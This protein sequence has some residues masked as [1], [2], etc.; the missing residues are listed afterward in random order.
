MYR[1]LPA[2]LFCWLA[3]SSQTD[4]TH[5]GDLRLDRIQAAAKAY[6]RDVGEFPMTAA[7][8]VVVTDTSGRPKERSEGS[9]RFVFHGYNAR[10]ETGVF[11]LYLGKRENK[12]IKEGAMTGGDAVLLVGLKLRKAADGAVAIEQPAQAGQPLL[13]GIRE[14]LCP[15]FGRSEGRRDIRNFCGR[16]EYRLMPEGTDGLRLQHFNLDS[17]NLPAKADTAALGTVQVLTYHVDEDFEEAL[18][19]G[20]PKPFLVPKRNVTTIGTNKGKIVVTNQ[21]APETPGGRARH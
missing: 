13:V 4:S 18:L 11:T 17:T 14:P 9:V 6:L 16:S 7:V 3:A 8:A 10:A 19:P 15:E 2:L 20:D 5:G 12:V 1:V 21:Y